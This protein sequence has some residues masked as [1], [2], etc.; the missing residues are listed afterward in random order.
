MHLR[1]AVLASVLGFLPC[2]T[3]GQVSHAPDDATRAWMQTALTNWES[4]CTQHLRLPAE[5][6]PWII[7]YDETN[8][9]HLEADQKLLPN[10]H[11]TGIKLTFAGKGRELLQVANTNGVWNPAKQY[12]PTG[13]SAPPHTFAMPYSNGQKCFFIAAVPSF[14]RSRP[15]ADQK[16][17]W[18]SFSLG[19]VAHEM[20]H[21]RQL[22][23][24]MRRIRKLRETHPVPIGIDDNFIQKTY[25]TNAAYKALFEEE[26]LKFTRAAFEGATPK[27]SHRLL[28]EALDLAEQRRARFFVDDR[29]VHREL[30]DI[31]L[32]L[33]GVA[34]LSEFQTARQRARPGELWQQTATDIMK[35]GGSW[36]QVEGLALFILIDRHVPDWRK[37]FLSDSYPSP[38]AVLREV[39]LQGFRSPDRPAR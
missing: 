14:I 20:T 6:L 37:K 2:V 16:V 12:L 25:K 30:D 31:F 1:A 23:D 7:F 5:P 33:E 38:F 21:T 34:M 27:L 13:A 35:R 4:I 8:A 24:V 29:A 36:S 9:W 18:E 3:F 32:V 28:T 10:A 26:Q 11:D 22:V 15:G 17:N 19:S 39:Q